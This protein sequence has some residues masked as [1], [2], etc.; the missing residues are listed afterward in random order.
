MARFASLLYGGAAYGVFFVTFLYAIGFVANFGVPKS[1]DSGTPAPLFEALVVN[2]LLLGLF[3]VQHSLM[4]RPGFKRIWTKIVPTQIERSTFVLFTSLALVL[5]FWQWR[6]MPA[7]IWTVE[8][9]F[10]AG[11]LQAVSLSG[12]GLVL[13][14]TC[15]ISHFELFGLKQVV[16]H[17][18]GRLAGEP[19]FKTP[20]LYRVVRHPIYLGF[21]MAF[22][23]APAMTEGHLLFALATTGYILIGIQLEERDLI[24]MF[25]AQYEAYRRRVAMLVPGLRPRAERSEDPSLLPFAG[26]H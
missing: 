12:W 10:A 2:T 23:A 25:G 16:L 3:A 24:A 1:I 19:Q 4:A 9:P 18:R 21:L 7:P 15:L 20:S 14:S 26:E 5:L 8:N 17:W 11:L 6:P 22:W 13:L